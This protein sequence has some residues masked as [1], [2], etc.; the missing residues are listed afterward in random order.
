MAEFD[1]AGERPTG[2]PDE[3]GRLESLDS[4]LGDESQGPGRRD[5]RRRRD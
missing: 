5:R 4:V 1:D 2:R 3:V